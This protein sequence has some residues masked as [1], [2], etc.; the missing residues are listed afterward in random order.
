MLKLSPPQP[1][2]VPFNAMAMRL[3]LEGCREDLATMRRRDPADAFGGMTMPPL[4]QRLHAVTEQLEQMVGLLQQK[5][6]DPLTA[7]DA[8]AREADHRIKNSLQIVSGLLERQAAKAPDGMAREALH[9]A[10]SRVAAVAQLHVALLGKAEVLATPHVALDGYLGGI[11]DRLQQVVADTGAVALHVALAPLTMPAATAQTLGLVVS[12]LVINTWRHAP[13]TPER[14]NIWISGEAGSGGYALCIEDDGPGLPDGF[15]P[16]GK[17]NGLGLRL[18]SAL[19]EQMQVRM[20][21][22]QGRGVRFTL[23]IPAADR[24]DDGFG[25]TASFSPGGRESCLSSGL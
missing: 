20:K 10:G 4:E 1:R 12:E 25:A 3:A 8:L 5:V 22:D 24:D 2:D 14:R 11:C 9:L 21:V 15:N 7:A 23:M 13:G 18:I 6:V 16:G 17:H 19:A